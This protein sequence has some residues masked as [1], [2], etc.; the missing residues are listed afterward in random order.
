MRILIIILINLR[1]G[2]ELHK[3]IVKELEVA[4]MIEFFNRVPM[5]RI[6]NRLSKDIINI[7]MSIAIII[8]GTLSTIGSIVFSLAFF[9]KY[10]DIYIL[11]PITFFVFLIILLI[12]FF[13]KTYR[14]VIRL[15]A[16]SRS[17]IC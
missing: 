17:P 4:D 6:M 9:V 1:I 2:R 12:V 5:G 15:E 8:S 3:K 10:V 11:I 13:L 16:I 14:E 7:D